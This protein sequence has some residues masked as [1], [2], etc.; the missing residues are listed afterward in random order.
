MASGWTTTHRCSPSTGRSVHPRSVS[1]TFHRLILALGFTAP[2]GVSPPVVHSSWLHRS[3]S[4]VCCVSIDRALTQLRA[5]SAALDVHGPRRPR[6]D[7][8]LSDHHSTA[9][10]GGQPLIRGLR[11][12]SPGQRW[13]DEKSVARSVPAQLLH[14]SP[15]RREGPAP[16]LGAQLPRHDPAPARVRRRPEALQDHAPCSTD[17]PSG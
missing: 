12:S 5:A 17:L 7:G 9:H 3:R 14:R 4:G 11:R 13:R 2:A 10:A 1:M 8:D 15:D 6:L 16:G